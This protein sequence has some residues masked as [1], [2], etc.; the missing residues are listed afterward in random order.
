LVQ[1]P[2]VGSLFYLAALAIIARVR[3]NGAERIEAAPGR[4]ALACDPLP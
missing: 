1:T 4:A 3:T 2:I